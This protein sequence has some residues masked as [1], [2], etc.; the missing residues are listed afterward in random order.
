MEQYRREHGTYPEK[1]DAIKG[2][3]QAPYFLEYH[4][5]QEGYNFDFPSWD[6]AISIDSYVY[7]SRNGSWEMEN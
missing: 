7:D 4:K 6:D 2:M 3:S 5:N 1:L